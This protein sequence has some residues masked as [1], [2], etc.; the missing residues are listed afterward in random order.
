[1][2]EADSVHAVGSVRTPDRAVNSDSGGVSTV[3][4]GHVTSG[5]LTSPADAGVRN[6]C[7]EAPKAVP[8]VTRLLPNSR[9]AGNK[10]A[11]GAGVRVHQGARGQRLLTVSEVADRLTVSAA[12]VY[13]L[14]D[15]GELAHV[16]VLNAIRVGEADLASFLTAT[17]ADR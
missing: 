8:F 9:G 5:N 15:R 16:R 2:G 12:T 14:C 1:V 11:A 17:R 4:T 10:K 6:F 13:K 7:I 3:S